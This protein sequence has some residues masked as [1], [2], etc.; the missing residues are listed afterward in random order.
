MVTDTLIKLLLPVLVS[1]IAYEPCGVSRARS[2]YKWTFTGDKWPDNQRAWVFHSTFDSETVLF[3]VLGFHFI[4]NK[5]FYFRINLIYKKN[6]E[7][8]KGILVCNDNNSTEIRSPK[9]QMHTFS[10]CWRLKFQDQGIGRN[11]FFWHF[12]FSFWLALFILALY[13]CYNQYWC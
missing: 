1:L 7:V 11:G 3:H 8:N 2:F 4:K 13:I 10:L 6:W 5:Y 9:Q 12:P